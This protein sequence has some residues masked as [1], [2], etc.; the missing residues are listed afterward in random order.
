MSELRIYRIIYVYVDVCFI[1]VQRGAL[2]GTPGKLTE[3][4]FF[5]SK[6]VYEF[7]I[8]DISPI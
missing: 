2:P 5:T 3:S 7:V 1:K 8:S 6:P 4:L